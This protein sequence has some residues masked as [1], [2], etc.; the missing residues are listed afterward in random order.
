MALC[1]AQLHNNTGSLMS[2]KF[3]ILVLVSC[4]AIAGTMDYEDEVRAA[5]ISGGPGIY[6]DK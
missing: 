4:Y 3:A 5:E 1:I 2:V 6:H